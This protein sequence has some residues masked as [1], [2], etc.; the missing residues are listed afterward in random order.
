MLYASHS[1]NPAVHFLVLQFTQW[2]V[3]LGLLLYGPF[4][5]NYFGNSAGITE[6]FSMCG[7]DFVEVY[8]DPSQAG[9]VA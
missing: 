1:V 7:G 8:S 3:S 9:M 4:L 5:I 2:F 6:G